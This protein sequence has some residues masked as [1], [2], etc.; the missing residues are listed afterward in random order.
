MHMSYVMLVCRA[1][2]CVRVRVCGTYATAD[3]V[4]ALIYNHPYYKSDWVDCQGLP[5]ALMVGAL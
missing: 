2:Q 4:V 5:G 1:L 3:V